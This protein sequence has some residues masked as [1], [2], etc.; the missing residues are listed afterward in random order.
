M[1]HKTNL[2]NATSFPS[3]DNILATAFGTP[4]NAGP[5]FMIALMCLAHQPGPPPPPTG[6]DASTHLRKW[7]K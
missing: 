4:R 2:I 5:I 3:A 1:K 7:R 6:G